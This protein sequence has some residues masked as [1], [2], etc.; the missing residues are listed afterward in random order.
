MKERINNDFISAMKNKEKE[1]LAVMKMLKGAVQLEE[2]NQK[3]EL[4]DDEIVMIV[5]KQ[6]KTRKESIVE[7]EK[8]NRT[9][10]I[11]QANFEIK[12]LEEYMPEQMSEEEINKVIDE[13]FTKVNSAGPSDMGEIMGMI[14]PILKGKAD[15]GLVNKLIRDRLNNK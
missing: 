3:K 14:S 9:D 1:K 6:I 10:L 13:V 8:G 5:A 7:F 2:L 15:L 12:V 11:E 4:T